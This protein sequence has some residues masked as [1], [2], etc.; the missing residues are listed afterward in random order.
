M[1]FAVDGLVRALPFMFV[2]GFITYAIHLLQEIRA[3]I[4]QLKDDTAFSL[5]LTALGANKPF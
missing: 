4:R 3:D 5:R 1:G 2:L